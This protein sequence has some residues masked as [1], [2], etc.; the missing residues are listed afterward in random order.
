MSGIRGLRR[1]RRFVW[2]V[3]LLSVGLLFHPWG[4]LAFFVT[5]WV[6]GLVDA[7]YCQGGVCPRCAKRFSRYRM[8]IVIH[9]GTLLRDAACHRCGL[10]FGLRKQYALPPKGDALVEQR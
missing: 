3:W 8:E 6:A 4:L 10:P 2:P 1:F 7:F 5:T 9:D